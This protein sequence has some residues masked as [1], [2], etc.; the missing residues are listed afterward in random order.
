MTTVAARRCDY[1][2]EPAT[3]LRARLF[4]DDPNSMTVAQEHPACYQ[5][6]M[7]DLVLVS[8]G[9]EGAKPQPGWCHACGEWTPRG[10]VVAEI[11]TANA[12]GGIVVRCLA[13]CR[14]APD[15]GPSEPLHGYHSDDIPA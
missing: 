6:F 10:R 9:V 2:Q 15:P 5:V 7:G 4:Y 12:A 13:C 1:C 8:G 11:H 3:G 14:T